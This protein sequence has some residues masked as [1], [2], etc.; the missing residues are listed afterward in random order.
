MAN[1]QACYKCRYRGTIP[2][3]CH[4]RCR[5]PLAES[6]PGKARTDLGIRGH[7]VGIRGGW[8]VW[9][10]NFDPTWLLSCSGFVAVKGE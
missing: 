3:D 5:H 4:T 8:F 9:P 7:D 10:Y 1:K 2:G 6:D